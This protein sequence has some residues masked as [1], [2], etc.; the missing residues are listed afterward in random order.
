MIYKIIRGIPYFPFK[1]LMKQGIGCS[2]ETFLPSDGNIG[3]DQLRYIALP[4][5]GIWYN[6]TY[7]YL[8]GRNL[9]PPVGTYQYKL[10]S[11][12]VFISRDILIIRVGKLPIHNP[13]KTNPKNILNSRLGRTNYAPTRTRWGPLELNNSYRS[14]SQ[15]WLL[16]QTTLQPH[17]AVPR[18]GKKISG[19][20][21]R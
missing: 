17:Q 16:I 21:F 1:G 19:I 13:A 7:E 15:N 14:I 10:I 11:P 6:V 2:S 18:L 8:K 3:W 12:S 5:T 9:T 20:S 4:F